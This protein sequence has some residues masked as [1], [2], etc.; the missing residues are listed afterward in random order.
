MQKIFHST[1]DCF[2]GV[3]QLPLWVVYL[4][5]GVHP[6]RFFHVHNYSEIAVIISGPAKHIL[7]AENVP[8]ATGDVLVIHPGAIHAYDETGEMEII[9]LVFDL[10]RL[11]LPQLDAYSLP[12]FRKFF[13]DSKN[14]YNSAKPVARLSGEDLGEAVRMIQKL[15]EELKHPQKG[16][17]FYSLALFMEILVFIARKSGSQNAGR[18]GSF[19]IGD[20]IRYLHN[21]YTEPIKLKKLAQIAKMSERTLLRHFHAN[22]GCS[23]IEYLQKN[24]STAFRR[25]VDQQQQFH[26]GDRQ[27]VRILR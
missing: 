21:H 11:S 27:F 24:P 23:P 25:L 16:S 19:L 10:T 4:R 6:A 20:V 7:N 5:K 12:L 18:K 22:A 14:L 3:G 2:V 17:L 9:N 8:L 1:M 15:E 26:S 13:P